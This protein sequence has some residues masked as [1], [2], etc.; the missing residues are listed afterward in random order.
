M[1]PQFVIRPFILLL[2][3]LCMC[4][5]MDIHVH[6]CAHVC[7]VMGMCAGVCTCIDHGA[8]GQQVSPSIIHLFF[9]T[10]SFTDSGAQQFVLT[11][12]S[13]DPQRSSCLSLLC[14]GITGCASV[15]LCGSLGI[16]LRSSCLC[17][18]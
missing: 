17:D 15:F 5:C 1:F 10:G 14:T 18:K 7:H 6:V 9:E 16:E 2:L 3:C 12:L 11:S 8:Y 13:R 4:M